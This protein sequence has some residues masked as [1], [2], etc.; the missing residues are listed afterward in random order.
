[1]EH[2]GNICSSHHFSGGRLES[3]SVN[4]QRAENG[5]LDP[6]SLGSAFGAPRLLPLNTLLNKSFRPLG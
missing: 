1:M 4:C 5:A 6:S 3:V 2:V